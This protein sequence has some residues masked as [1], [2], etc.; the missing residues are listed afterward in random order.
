MD[1]R[2]NSRSRCTATQ[3]HANRVYETGKYRY[4]YQSL[5]DAGFSVR[6]RRGD[7]RVEVAEAGRSAGRVSIGRGMNRSEF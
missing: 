1:M 7:R 5:V 2:L 3:P 4:A 6:V